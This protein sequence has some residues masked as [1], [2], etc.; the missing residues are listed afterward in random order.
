MNARHRAW[1]RVS[2]YRSHRCRSGG[3][4][5]ARQWWAEAAGGEQGEQQTPPDE[6]A[7]PPAAAVGERHRGGGRRHADELTRFRAAAVGG[8]RSPLRTRRGTTAI[9]IMIDPQNP[10][11][12]RM[13]DRLFAALVNGPAMSCRPHHSRQRIDWADLSRLKDAEPGAALLSLLGPDRAARLLARVPPAKADDEDRTAR[14]AWLAQ[15][16][17]VTKLRVIADDARTYAADTGVAAMSVGFP[18]LSL[19][20]GTFGGAGSRRV[21]APLA[22]VPVT[23]TVKAGT[24]QTVE[25]ACAAD[26]A[27]RV[28]PN[29]ALL[30]WLEQQTGQP[31]VNPYDDAEGV[32]P[33]REVA[34]L[35]RAVAARVDLPVPA[36]FA[37]GAPPEALTLTPT[38]GSDAD[39]AGAAIVIGA[40]LG[41]FPASNQG[42]LTDTR[43]LIANGSP[44]GPLASFVR[45]GVSL[46]LAT[47]P[48]AATDAPPAEQA[49]RTFAD[50]R[51]VTLA[52]P[53][54]A[55]A[56]RLARQASGLVIHGP[57]GTG[58]S[59]TIAN[60]IGDHL[61]HGERVLFVCDKR[62][63]LDVVAD[64]L[65]SL[66]LADLCATVHDPQR[67]Q[68]ELYKSVRE[69]LDQLADVPLHPS[70]EK[71]V[72][73]IDAEL[74][75]IHDELTGYYADLMTTP[76]GPRGG[77]GSFHDLVGRWLK[78]SAGGDVTAA[79][80]TK[81]LQEVTTSELDRNRDRL[82]DVLERG[83]AT[84]YATNSW[85]TAAG[86]D[87]ARFLA[88]PM[89]AYRQQLAR[90]A[91][92]A[93]AT[94]ATIDPLHPP[95]D[96]DPA[97]DLAAE[98]KRRQDV[99][100]RLEALMAMPL[101]HGGH[102][103]ARADADVRAD[104]S[105]L[106]AAGDWIA[107]VASGPLDAALKSADDAL[108]GNVAPV[109][110]RLAA[111]RATLDAY[112]TAFA[113]RR[114]TYRALRS[115]VPSAD[116][117]VAL[118]WMAADAKTA[119]AARK[120]LDVAGPIVAAVAA[121]P[122]DASLM[123]RYAETP[124]AGAKMVESL[125]ALNAYLDV[126]GSWTVIFQGAKKRAAEPVVRPFG[127]SLNVAS[128]GRVR[129][130]LSA[131][132]HRD[133]LRAAVEAATGEVFAARPDDD[134]LLGAFT[135]HRGV[136][137]ALSALPT[138]GVI[139]D[140]SETP[141]T[142]SA[143]NAQL[144]AT[145]TAAEVV[146]GGY[147]RPLNATTATAVSA[148][149]LGTEARMR[150]ANTLGRLWGLPS[151]GDWMADA[152]LLRLVDMLERLLELLLVDPFTTPVGQAIAKALTGQ[153]D[154]VVV[155]LR[156]S[157]ARAAAVTK[158]EATLAEAALFSPP[159]LKQARVALRSNK[160]I[161]RV[162]TVL[163]EKLPT[164]EGV[165]RTREGLAKLPAAM[166]TAAAALGS[167]ATPAAAGYAAVKRHV[168]AGEIGRRLAAAP[169]LQAYDDHRLKT[170]FDNY[171]DL[172]EQ[173]KVAVRKVIQ[174]RWV[175]KQK[176]RLLAKT[177]T[178][179]N[180]MATDL[181]LRLTTRG[182]RA[183]RLRQVIARGAKTDGGDP[184]FDLRPVWM[185][186]PETVA[187]LFPREP[188]FDVVVFDEAS[189]CRLEEALPVMTRARP[190]W[191]SPATRSSWPPTRFFESAVVKSEEVEA[192]TDQEFFEAAQG[193]VEDLLTAA[194]G[195]DVHQ[196]YLDVHYRSR[197]RDLIGFS[198][199]H[200]YGS[201]LQAVPGHPNHRARSAPITIVR[202]DGVYE[203]RRNKGEA[204]AV[205][206]LVRELLGQSA[207]PSIGIACFN[208]AQR[209][210]IVETLDDA[211]DADPAFA[212]RLGEAPRAAEF[213]QQ[214]GA[215][216]QEPGER[217]GG[218]AGP[219]DRQH[220]V[221]PER[222]RAVQAAVRAARVGR[223][224]A[225]A[226]RAGDA[227]AGGGTR[228]DVDSAV[229]VR[230]AAGRAGRA[231][232]DRGVAAVRLPAPRRAVAGPVRAER[233]G[234]GLDDGG[235]YGLGLP[236]PD[237]D[238]V[239]VRR[240]AGRA[241]GRPVRPR[242]RR[243]LGQRRVRR[244]CGRARP[245]Q[246]AGRDGRSAVRPDAVRR[247]RRPGR[248]GRVPDGRP[249]AAGVAAGPRLVAAL[250]PRPDRRHGR[251]RGGGRRR[252][253][254]RSAALFSELD[255]DRVGGGGDDGGR[256]DGGVAAPV[257][258]TVDRRDPAGD[259]RPRNCRSDADREEIHRRPVA[260]PRQLVVQP[261]QAAAPEPA[262]ERLPPEAVGPAGVVG[263]DGVDLD[264]QRPVG[265]EI[266]GRPEE[267]GAD[268]ASAVG[269]IYGQVL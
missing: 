33:W 173:K 166:A 155:A 190:G 47:Q 244:R 266:D 114:A 102:W 187:Q 50:E 239:G 224:R 202:A 172:S 4:Q 256:P 181:R 46:D 237:A 180:S 201:R 61:A 151:I 154:A 129:A 135:A 179:L 6:P 107:A 238:A 189:Q 66:G 96:A 139:G 205:V 210:L 26:G 235:R 116:E 8:R 177:G 95:F 262:V 141:A 252:I 83:E 191:S 53:C 119:T 250:L 112:V 87:L 211:A 91:A 246:S 20:P 118:R 51:M 157:P 42:L 25:L 200:F 192:E 121:N 183:T 147:G 134:E 258:V 19:P 22:F 254:V 145:A 37:A 223:G 98:A 251:D 64:R 110:D 152:D 76:H 106:T 263:A 31:V 90:C 32:D 138:G 186:S 170:A 85:R 108:R 2:W 163:A 196:S 265:D 203:K 27:D 142:V 232:A 123:A 92:V 167:A 216:R 156:N 59:Q 260:R 213:E 136:L 175:A 231:D 222:G 65:Q 236:S 125:A 161:A 117:A 23:L 84:G 169:N 184:L 99:A 131:V 21:L 78:E 245:D 248:V 68:R 62:T 57:P 144:G 162:V 72:A 143:I 35:V 158:A 215:V 34:E 18:L 15:Q 160:P 82:R 89:D 212:K 52:D 259:H 1:L 11:L 7:A 195:L 130:L 208:L 194:L 67:D 24:K 14:D 240:R 94:D 54:Q 124:M 225:A 176:D 69:Q 148:F 226:E 115:A 264:Q 48:A 185:A 44:A 128:A 111:D 113:Q 17:L 182:E 153:A 97:T 207:P 132:Q 9:P 71:S 206:A 159:F 86:L 63:A 168:L 75:R 3:S 12:V 73:R 80:D 257:H 242:H 209:D 268:A 120:R 229:G 249:R 217:A 137:A 165:I 74:Q 79:L 241:A 93:T 193:E 146:V 188:I 104:R 43:E 28:V 171:R 220:D 219:P 204:D 133:D 10:V 199:D 5:R 13:L 109:A 49:A 101:V 198:N 218:R 58:K 55:R 126:A 16:A 234:A 140:V 100:G 122:L 45:H 60:V 38:P 255:A 29:V 103:A 197:N 77:P 150:L 36:A 105:T 253:A 267:D 127:L 70:V 230:D 243:L 88:E 247:Q 39:E 228:R 56:V 227:G 261:D 178:R 81:A 149:L 41:L 233:A 40:V 30:A 269:G 174:H 221:R 214:R 164:L